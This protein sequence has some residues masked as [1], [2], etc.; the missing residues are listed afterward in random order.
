MPQ[1]LLRALRTAATLLPLFALHTGALAQT[2]NEDSKLIGN[3]ALS[4]DMFG[5]SIGLDGDLA[6]VGSSELSFP[7][8]GAGSA[9]VFER[10]TGDWSQS[11]R[12]VAPDGGPAQAFGRS[13]AID[14]GTI[15]VGSDQDDPGGP[16]GMTGAVF[17][18]ER[19]AAETW[20]RT[21]RLVP[22]DGSAGDLFGWSVDLNGERALVG[23]W[24][25]AGMSGAA[26]VY[27]R[28]AGG[29]IE[30]AKLTA[31]DGEPTDELGFHVGLDEARAIAGARNDDDANTDAGAAYVFARNGTA[32][33]LESKLTVPGQAAGSRT[34]TAVAIDADRALLGAPGA[35]VSGA[36]V[37]SAI[38]FE[39][40]AGSWRLEATLAGPPNTERFSFGRSVALQG[41]RAV[42][43]EPASATFGA[44][45]VFD[46]FAAGWARTRSLD[47][48]D[49]RGG[50]SFG[51]ASAMDGERVLVS[52]LCGEGLEPGSGAAYV[53][54]VPSPL[55]VPF[56][57]GDGTALCPCA[58]Q[59]T[60]GQGEGCV[61]STAFA[62]RLRASGSSSL[63]R[64]DLRL[65][66]SGL[67]PDA[68]VLLATSTLLGTSTPFG[69]GLACLAGS[70]R[71]LGSQVASTAGGVVFDFDSAPLGVTP[72]ERR[73]FQMIYRDTV[74]GSCGARAN[75]TN[76]LE[77]LFLP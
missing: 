36:P 14:A 30:E 48:S 71:R 38:V 61:N 4:M 76:G 75:L 73:A 26:Y 3:A 49:N 55:G 10:I 24:R 5:E 54:E 57:F 74:H 29:W 34:G 77:V 17:V 6:V 28:T 1:E 53:F 7:D 22:S 47:P 64:N 50:Q 19:T 52:S 62:G 67:P 31:P 21:A 37:G 65:E 32:W 33:S 46:R 59:G 68:R 40:Q 18:F 41:T 66:G 23:S 20:E 15:L 25:H 44:A 2:Q 39:R 58:N 43:G 63:M 16:N 56:C 9:Y 69:S 13:V 51:F 70:P 12:L 11:A 72:G 8:F 27:R 60:A 45:H 35:V 42:V